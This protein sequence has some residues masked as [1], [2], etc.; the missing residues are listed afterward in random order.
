MLTSLGVV[1]GSASIILLVALVAG[2]Q[3]STTAQ[4]SGNRDLT[5]IEVM[6]GFVRFTS[7]GGSRTISSSSDSQLVLTNDIVRQFS[8]IENV[9]KV[10]PRQS[11]MGNSQLTIQKYVGRA[12][13]TGIGVEDLAE[14]GMSVTSGST[15]LKAR[16]AVIGSKL[17]SSFY[18]PNYSGPEATLTMSLLNKTLKLTLSKNVAGSQQRKAFTFRVTGILKETSTQSDYAMYI[19]MKDADEIASWQNNKRIN[20]NTDSYSNLL[21]QVNDTKNVMA[22][23]KTITNLGYQAMTPQTMLESI[24]SLFTTLQVVFGGVGAITLLVAAIG[25][26]NTMTMAILERTKEIGLLKALG[27]TNGDILSLFLGEAAGIG[28]IGGI[29]G[30]AAGVILGEVI[31]S[32]AVPYLASQATTSGASASVSAVV[33][34]PL[35]LPVF[36][37]VF[38][39]LMGLL[40]GLYPSLRGASLSPVDALKYE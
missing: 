18:R 39:A 20:H 12:N 9:S 40:S 32:I 33:S 5:Q 16:S 35:Y 34:I 22:V 19:S 14:L 27:A 4:F 31:N 2:L 29:G 38:S 24:N 17:A 8:E 37:L 26:A 28:L 10:I 11:V 36:A 30:T 15:E 25:I 7:G 21:V 13:I 1:I 3:E 23:A 6:A